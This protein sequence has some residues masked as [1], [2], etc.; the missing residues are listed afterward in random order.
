MGDLIFKHK[1]TAK[2]IVKLLLFLINLQQTKLKNL[3]K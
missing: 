1:N 2:F 3:S